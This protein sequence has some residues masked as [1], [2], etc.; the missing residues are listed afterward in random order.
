MIRR[1][2]TVA[3]VAPAL[4]AV[5]VAAAP[6]AASSGGDAR[7]ATGQARP[8]IVSVV[9]RGGLCISGSE[10][11]STFRITDATV[12]GDGYRARRL[13]PAERAELLRALKVFD[14]AYLGAHPFTGTCPIAYDGQESIYRFRGVKRA[15]AS[16]TYDLRG[17]R[18]V[19]VTERILGSL[20]LR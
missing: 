3:G 17:V 18:A 10:C 19:H 6:G 20:K 1:R 7:A 5:W 9:R 14:P 2:I 13:K 11:R 16:C 8:P 12:T 15:L 4:I